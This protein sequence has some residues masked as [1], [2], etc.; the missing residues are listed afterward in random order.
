MIQENRYM[1]PNEHINLMNHGIRNYFYRCNKLHKRFYSCMYS[2]S[3][4]RHSELN[5][6]SSRP[7][8][9]IFNQMFNKWT[10]IFYKNANILWTILFRRNNVPLKKIE[11]IKLPKLL[12]KMTFG[13]LNKIRRM[14]KW[15][16]RASLYDI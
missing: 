16:R 12:C 8:L 2:T 9:I 6:L 7:S 1:L 5:M 15:S 13:C 4:K 10:L 11:K 14:P 3:N